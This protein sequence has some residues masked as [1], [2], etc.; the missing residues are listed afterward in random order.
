MTELENT[1]AT[2]LLEE[3]RRKRRIRPIC[4]TVKAI[5]RSVAR[6]RV[7]LY[8]RAACCLCDATDAAREVRGKGLEARAPFHADGTCGTALGAFGC[9]LRGT[10]LRATFERRERPADDPRHAFVEG[11]RGDACRDRSRPFNADFKRDALKEHIAQT[12]KRCR[13][14]VEPEGFGDG[15]LISGTGRS[16]LHIDS[17]RKPFG[18]PNRS[19]TDPLDGAFRRMLR[20]HDRS[21]EAIFCAVA[22]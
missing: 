14:T 12:I 16:N 2:E 5:G 8:A 9:V 10:R 11:G 22:I 1:A 7:K 15:V 18:F 17:E 6:A 20:Q 13:Y 3:F 21:G 19:V 4:G